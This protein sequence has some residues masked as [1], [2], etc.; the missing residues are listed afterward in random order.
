MEKQE[1]KND[2]EDN[3]PVRSALEKC[4]GKTKREVLSKASKLNANDRLAIIDHFKIEPQNLAGTIASFWL[5]V[6]RSGAGVDVLLGEPFFT[7]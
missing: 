5:K 4:R 6:E 3:T 7:E 2:V 1:A